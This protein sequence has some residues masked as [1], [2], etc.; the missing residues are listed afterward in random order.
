[1]ANCLGFL[2]GVPVVDETGLTGSY[3]FELRWS[4]DFDLA[5]SSDQKKQVERALREQL[6]LELVPDR[7]PIEMLV[8]E[9]VKN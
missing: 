4:G 8:V 5:K 3:D 9:R 6:G 7:R 2:L 1:V